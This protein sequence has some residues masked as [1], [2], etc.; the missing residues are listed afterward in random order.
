VDFS[1]PADAERFRK[2]LRSWFAANL[3]PGVVG[4]GK[5]PGSG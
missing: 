4:A 5:H 1:Y 2:E 3:T